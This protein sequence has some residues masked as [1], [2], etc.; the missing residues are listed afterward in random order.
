[1]RN[2]T[3]ILKDEMSAAY[4]YGTNEILDAAWDEDAATALDELLSLPMEGEAA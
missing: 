4:P 1:M 3:E 2:L